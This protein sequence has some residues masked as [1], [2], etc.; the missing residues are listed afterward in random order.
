M[1]KVTLSVLAAVAMFA[2]SAAV[3]QVGV[4]VAGAKAGYGLD[5][6]YDLGQESMVH[7]MIGQTDKVEG[8]DKPQVLFGSVDYDLTAAISKNVAVYAG[9]GVGER[10][11]RGIAA[12]LPLGIMATFDRFPVQVAYE[13]V[14]SLT[15]GDTSAD[16][17]TFTDHSLAVRYLLK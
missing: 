16:R 3:A 6:T 1:K 15:L 13:V 17:H 11:S 2:S 12:R 8:S 9:A 7:G 4:G 5:L 14:P 10:Q